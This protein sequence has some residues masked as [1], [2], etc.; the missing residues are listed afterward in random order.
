PESQPESGSTMALETRYDVRTQVDSSAPADRFPEMCGS[1]TLAME[2]SST[3]MNVARVTVTAITQGVIEPSGIR[4][5]DSNLCFTARLLP[6]EFFYAGRACLFQFE[7][8][9]AT[10]FMPG[11]RTA[12]SCG[13]GSRTIF[14]GTRCTTFT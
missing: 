4:N 2:V 3:S 8:T 13:M 11:R 10:T 1:A 9:V 7:M 5:F 14:T 12:F 6:S